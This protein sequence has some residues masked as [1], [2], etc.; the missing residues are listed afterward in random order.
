VIGPLNSSALNRAALNAAILRW[1]MKASV[2][3]RVLA[4][5]PL[6]RLQSIQ[7]ATRYV[8]LRRPIR[9]LMV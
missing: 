2:K 5:P 1:V 3:G 8:A 7:P 9:V 6:L 4:L